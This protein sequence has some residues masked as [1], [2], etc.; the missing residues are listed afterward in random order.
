MPQRP[1]LQFRADELADRLSARLVGAGEVEVRGLNTLEQS[2]PGDMTFIGS[3]KHAKLWAESQAAAA[4]VTDGVDIPQV[5][6]T[7]QGQEKPRRALLYVENADLAMA[8]LLELFTAAVSSCEPAGIHPSAVVDPSAQVDPT[9]SIGP[10]AAIGAGTTIGA[11]TSIEAN[12]TIGPEC[13]IGADCTIRAGAVIRERCTL[14][15]RVSLHPNVVIGADGFGYRPDGQGGLVKMPHIGT[16]VIGDDVELGACTTVDRGKFGPTEI[17][18][19]TKLD[20][21]CQIGHNVRIGRGCV[22]AAMTGIAGSTVIGDFCQIGGQ[23][24]I[25]DH[26]EIGSGV[27]IAAHSAVISSVEPG[28]IMGGVPAMELRKF[29]RVH[30]SLLRLPDFMKAATRRFGSDLGKDG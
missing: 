19:H 26:V 5:G 23:V 8:E 15:D 17:G 16:V 6:D 11:G 4:V 10:G 22:C 25:A 24:G 20:N 21:L 12:V 13:I 28:K 3:D 1:C 7:Q 9:V 18:P 29:W 2:G 30:A 14:G 27:K